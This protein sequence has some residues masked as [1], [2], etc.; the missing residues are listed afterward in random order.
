MA[1][2]FVAIPVDNGLFKFIVGLPIDTDVIF[3][4]SRHINNGDVPV[5]F[6]AVGI[7]KGPDELIVDI[8]ITVQ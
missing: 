1:L 3:N 6:P 5:K 7:N 2:L 8:W 4:A